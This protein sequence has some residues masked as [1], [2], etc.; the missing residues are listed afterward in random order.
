MNYVAVEELLSRI[1]RRWSVRYK[2][3]G[4]ITMHKKPKCKLSGFVGIGPG[5]VSLFDVRCRIGSPD[6]F[7]LDDKL[8]IACRGVGLPYKP[9][10]R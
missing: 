10:D 1:H 6:Y 9:V 5:D 4:P 7:D 2:D 8:Q 3:L